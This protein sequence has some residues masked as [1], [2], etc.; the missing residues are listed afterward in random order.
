MLR[1]IDVKIFTAFFYL[2]LCFTS[3]TQAQGDGMTLLSNWDIDTLPASGAGYQYNDIWGYSA[4]GRE[5]AILGSYAGTWFFDVTDPENVVTVDY[6]AGGFNASIWR[7]YKTYEHYCYGVAD[8][9]GTSSL[10]IFD[11]STLPDSVHKIYDSD[12]FFVQ[13]HNLFIDTSNAVLYACGTDNYGSGLVLL[14]IS[15]PQDTP[16]LL[17]N[18]DLG[19]YSHDIYVRDDTIYCFAATTGVKIYELTDSN[20]I[21]IISELLI[22]PDKGYNHSGWV[23][24]DG[25]ILVFCDETSDKMVKVTNI[26]DITNPEVI[27]LFKSTLLCPQTNSL[28]HNPFIRDSLVFVSYYHD[29]IQVFDISDPYYPRRIA[30]YDT[31]PT[32]TTYSGGSGAWG[33]YPYL[34]SGN[35][36]A[37]DLKN[38]L[39]VLDFDPTFTPQTFYVDAAS[40]TDDTTGHCWENAFIDINQAIP[41]LKEGDSLHVAQGIYLPDNFDRKISFVFP[42]QTYIVG[43]FPLGGNDS[44][45]R[46]PVLYPTILSGNIGDTSS[47]ADDSYHIIQVNESNTLYLDGIQIK[48]GNHIG[49]L[50]N[51]YGSALINDGSTHLINCIVANQYGASDGY[52]IHNR[53]HLF[54]TNCTLFQNMELSNNASLKNTRGGTIH[55]EGIVQFKF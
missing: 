34:P 30:Y 28:A 11:L 52:V 27:S 33:V 7:D 2:L 53:N 24:D 41:R 17:G 21:E 47:Q 15:S 18:F 12:S 8:A 10:Q 37:S 4:N 38:G 23:S 49:D 55:F 3:S 1:Y 6:E 51:P 25:S 46:N 22:Y 35:I 29:G 13:A 39:F 44:I 19:H 36:L 26:S 43:G 50:S 9:G 14:D 32:D 40:I 31:E 16:S 5:Y 20:N 42:N 48:G 54:F 45:A